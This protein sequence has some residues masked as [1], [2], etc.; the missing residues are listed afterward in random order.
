MPCTYLAHALHIPSSSCA[1]KQTITDVA[2]DNFLTIAPPFQTPC[3]RMWHATELSLNGM[4]T[5]LPVD[6]CIQLWHVQM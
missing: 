1:G 6:L 4:W 5:C 2:N 3:V